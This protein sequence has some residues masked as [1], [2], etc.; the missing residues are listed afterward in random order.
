MSPAA[1]NWFFNA[2]NFVYWLSPSGVEWSR[3]FV[4]APSGASPLPLQL[5]F[6]FVLGTLSSYVGL[7][8]GH[9][10]TKVRR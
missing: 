6:A 2:D 8:F 7:W 3:S 4:S 1:R 10:M 9:W 5:A